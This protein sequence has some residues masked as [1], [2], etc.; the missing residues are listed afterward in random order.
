MAQDHVGHRWE[1]PVP[2]YLDGESSRTRSKICCA[3][4]R[5]KSLVSVCQWLNIHPYYRKTLRV[6]GRVTF[7]PKQTGIDPNSPHNTTHVETA[8]RGFW[9]HILL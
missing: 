1:T 4:L 6:S 7:R 9:S 5:S 2:F 3:N 8:Q